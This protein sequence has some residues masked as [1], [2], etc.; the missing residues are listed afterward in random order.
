MGWG[1]LTGGLGRRRGQG[2]V[3][4]GDP[5]ITEW[6]EGANSVH[7]LKIGERSWKMNAQ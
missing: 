6:I 1:L 2:P 7:T 3:C 5:G 4:L